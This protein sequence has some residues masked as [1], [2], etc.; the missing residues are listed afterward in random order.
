MRLVRLYL[1]T[2]STMLTSKLVTSPS[3]RKT[4]NRSFQTMDWLEKF[5]RK[6]S[7]ELSCV[8]SLIWSWTRKM[9]LQ[10]LWI[11]YPNLRTSLSCSST[12]VFGR[13]SFSVRTHPMQLVVEVQSPRRFEHQQDGKSPLSERLRF[14]P[15]LYETFEVIE[16]PTLMSDVN[17]CETSD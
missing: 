16:K 15:R 14:F 1:V 9:Q 10:S 8:L 12:L 4:S 5:R 3:S 6:S 11:L 2:S 7:D 17:S 13:S